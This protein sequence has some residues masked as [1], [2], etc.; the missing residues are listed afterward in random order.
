MM[1]KLLISMPLLG[2]IMGKVLGSKGENQRKIGLLY[3][4]ITMYISLYIL[5]T[6][7]NNN[8][9]Y[10][11][12][13]TIEISGIRIVLGLDG[14]SESLILVTT[15]LIP[16]LILI[17]ERKEEEEQEK[18]VNY[19]LLMES[20]LI[21]LFAS[22][23]IFIFFLMF[24]LLLIPMYLIIGRYGS[25]EGSKRIEAGYR[26]IIYSLIGSLIM[27]ISIIIIYIKYGSTNNEI[28]MVQLSKENFYIIKILWLSLF[29]SFA[30]K[31][32]IFPF[33]TWLPFV[34]VEAPTIGS[35][36]L[37]GIMLKLGGYGLI[38][39]TLNFLGD[40]K[41]FFIPIIIIMTLL[42]IIYGSL[43]TIRQI[44]FKKFIAYS[45]IVHMNFAI[46][47]LFSSEAEGLQGGCFLMI[48]HAFV[49]SALFFLIGLLYKRYH[50][51][52]IFYFYGIVSVMPIFASFF[53][54]FSLANVSF[55]FTSSFI[56]E[57]FILIS[58]F[59]FNPLVGFFLA[60]SLILST[61]FGLWFPNRFL[62]GQISPNMQVFLDLTLYEVLTLL[63][64]TFFTLLLGVFPQPLLSFYTL[65]VS[66]LC[67]I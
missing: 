44:D 12:R 22:L 25:P 46:L 59:K 62:F 20:M 31:V 45:S 54:F 30:I 1:L 16:I 23:D 66:T 15:I 37:A 26:F 32:P 60:F 49:S 50:T 43:T 11:Y 41:D 2:I 35:M 9:E 34:H 65:S 28:L 51:R 61:T 40:E 36:L 13:E 7:N 19:L 39:Y 27:L 5:L 38:R 53:F 4:I 47:G 6:T 14:I 24:E 52:I 21:M 42:S 64:L 29:F 8:I 17:K 58:S 56:S 3:S 48:S 63:P 57:I 67:I 55:P 10:Q 33:H 18:I